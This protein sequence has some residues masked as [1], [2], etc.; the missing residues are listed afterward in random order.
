M[1]ATTVQQARPAKSLRTTILIS[2][3]IVGSFDLTAASIQTLIYHGNLIRLFKYIATGVYGKEA[4]N[5]GTAYALQGILFHYCIAMIW[6][7]V[8]FLIYP[9]ISLLAKNRILTGILYGLVVWLVMNCVVVPL[10]NTSKN[11]FNL[12]RAMI[13]AG[14]LIV[15]IAIPLSY[16]VYAYYR[17]NTN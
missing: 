7:I 10:S 13:A 6:T 2:G 3:L 14:I 9:K 12:S 17:R 15:A 11:P 16:M 4:L 1:K 5:G 8:F